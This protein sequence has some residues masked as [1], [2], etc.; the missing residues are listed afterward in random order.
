[1]F[2][3]C[4]G[5]AK[6]DLSLAFDCKTSLDGGGYCPKGNKERCESNYEQGLEVVK[7]HNI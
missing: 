1:M 3:C 2:S 4:D 5:L 7:Q 6:G